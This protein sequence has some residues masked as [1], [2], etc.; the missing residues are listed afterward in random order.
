MAVKSKIHKSLS[1]GRSTMPVTSRRPSSK[2]RLNSFTAVYEQSEGWWVGQVLEVP[3]ALTQGKTLD[4]ARENLQEALTLIL[5]CQRDEAKRDL[6]GH[7]VIEEPILIPAL[8]S[9]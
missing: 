2:T 5:E 9:L 8:T 3:G 1:N 6:S 7:E 4:E